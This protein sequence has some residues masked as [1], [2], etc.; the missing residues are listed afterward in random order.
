MRKTS[1]ALWDKSVLESRLRD[2]L[3]YK[4]Y[5]EG[6]TSSR[7]VISASFYGIATEVG[8]EIMRL[9]GNAM[10]AALATALTQIVFSGGDYVSYAGIFGM[11]YFCAKDKQVYSVDALWNTPRNETDPLSIPGMT[12][13]GNGRTALI[14]GFM[15]GVEACCE[16][17]GTMPLADLLEPAI[18][19]CEHGFEILKLA[20]ILAAKKDVLGRFPETRALFFKENG[21]PY[22][23]GDVFKQP[24]VAAF[25][26]K[27][28]EQGA[29]YMY[30]G[31]WA[32]K[33]VETVRREG[34]TI[35]LEDLND[36]RVDIRPANRTRMFDMDACS[37]VFPV[38]G[39]DG[40][41]AILKAIEKGNVA[42]LGHLADNGRA[43]VR[44]SQGLRYYDA[45]NRHYMFKRVSDDFEKN[46]SFLGPDFDFGNL[47]AEKN[48]ELY[49]RAIDEGRFKP[50]YMT[51]PASAHS[52]CITVADEKG[53]VL[54]MTHS[55]NQVFFGMTGMSVDGI[56]ITDSATLNKDPMRKAGPGGRVEAPLAP[57][58]FLK[59]G[60][61]RLALS[62]IGVGL[63]EKSVC[64]AHNVLV[65]GMDIV[66]AQDAPWIMAPDGF[67]EMMGLPA[68]PSIFVDEGDFPQT[69]LTEA[70]DLGLR[71]TDY[72][73]ATI[74]MD[75]QGGP[76]LD[77]FVTALEIKDGRKTAVPV[78]WTNSK[79]VAV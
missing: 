40:V 17:F 1:P 21:E 59:D 38:S 39:G 66:S 75:V 58:I 7:A 60:R 35:T 43:L 45:W 49:W 5:H 56:M 62:G 79:A 51:A 32:R 33:F 15:A 61:P 10:D 52:D 26:R 72:H 57:L 53:N 46:R 54:A 77:G 3:I 18:F 8:A 23:A 37:T 47:F 55:A 36:Y 67:T 11:T 63:I 68:D 4:K 76:S 34:G 2:D 27:I 12:D 24:Q 28:Q 48:F 64:L 14:P 44:F 30:R 25:L 70:R 22:R 13:I 71:V 9:G 42:A 19:F 20:D 74:K 69:T 65:H 78:N 73:D 16:R 41:L 6:A 29:Q 50:A 31:D